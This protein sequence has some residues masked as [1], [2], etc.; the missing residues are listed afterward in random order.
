MTLLG[1]TS[2]QIPLGAPVDRGAFR[3][4]RRLPDAPRGLTV[5]PL[6]AHALS[7]AHGDLAQLRIVDQG[8]RQVPYLL[9]RGDDEAR[10]Q[11]AVGPRRTEGSRSV[12]RITLPYDRLRNEGL[13]LTT[14]ARVF[15]RNVTLRRGS[16]DHRWRSGAAL[17]VETWRSDDPD[18]AAPPLRMHLPN[19][20]PRTLDLIVDEGDN[21]PLPIASARLLLPPFALRF[22]HP[23]TPLFLLYG[24]RRVSEPRYDVALLAPRLTGAPARELALP[25]PAGLRNV[26]DDARGRRLFWIGVVIAGVVLVAML[27]RVVLVSPE[28]SRAP[29][30][31]T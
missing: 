8:G 18:R 26:D 25:P 12:Y 16:R 15:E 23:G 28:T 20:A 29:R 31:T 6:D 2:P 19:S 3:F 5:L 27:L 24:N 7:L 9:E 14:T 17:S 1:A 11:V 13:V 10:V 4:S 22:E 21:A 30:D